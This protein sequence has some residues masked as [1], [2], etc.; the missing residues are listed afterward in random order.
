ML[1]YPFYIFIYTIELFLPLFRAE[2]IYDEDRS[3]LFVNLR[4]KYES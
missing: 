1:F 4:V 3:S 2:R